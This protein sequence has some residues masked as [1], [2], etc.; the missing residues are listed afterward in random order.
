MSLQEQEIKTLPETVPTRKSPPPVSTR[1][2]EIGWM[3]AGRL[4]REDLQAIFDARIKLLENLRSLFPQFE[5][6][7]P[8]IQR[9]DLVR[10]PRIEPVD[11]LEAGSIELEA[12]HWDFVFVITGADLETHFKPYAFGTPARALS[13][14]VISTARLDPIASFSTASEEERVEVMIRRIF[15]LS[16]HLFGHLNGLFHHDDPRDFM[17]NIQSV[18]DL[19]H[20]ERFDEEELEHLLEELTE[21][22]DLRLEEVSHLPPHPI[23][24]FLKATWRNFDDIWNSVLQVKPWTFPLRLSRLSTA[25]FSALLILII[26]AEVWDLGMS[27]SAATVL[28]FS[29]GALI[30]TT[31]FIIERQHLLSRRLK[32][33]RLTEQTVITTMSV[34]ITIFLGMFTVY[35]LLFAVVLFL[36]LT[37]FTPTIIAEWAPLQEGQI[38]L[39]DYFVFAGFVASIGVILGALGASFEEAHYFR[40]IAF[41]DEET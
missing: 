2:I 8:V 25:A 34:I 15:A 27:L 22:A 26:T 30:L 24:F 28:A 13:A 38:T 20:M 16:M 17:Y 19:D 21:V 7:I 11:L 39:R 23:I 40:H 12:K 33:R 1:L 14:A 32:V 37:L 9:K 35:L 3:I 29:L 36:G 41:V 18:L 10:T 5:W 6:R 4:D 31:Y